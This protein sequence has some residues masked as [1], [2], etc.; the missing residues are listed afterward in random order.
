MAAVGDAE[1]ADDSENTD[2][3]TAGLVNSVHPKTHVEFKE[4]TIIEAEKENAQL[5]NKVSLFATDFWG[6]LNS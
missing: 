6:S 1:T 3:Q 5:V 4:T 2:S